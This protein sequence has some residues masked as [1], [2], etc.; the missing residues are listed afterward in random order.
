MRARKRILIA[1]GA[2]MD[3]VL[4]GVVI[5]FGCVLVVSF[6]VQVGLMR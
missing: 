5:T 3:A 1:M 2:G 6:L 4:I